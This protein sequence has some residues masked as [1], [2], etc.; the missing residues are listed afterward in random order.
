TISFCDEGDIVLTTNPAYVAY[1]A[2]IKLAGA[3]PYY[4]PLK[5]KNNYLPNLKDIPE[6]VLQKAKLLILNLPGNPVPA[7]P[8]ERFF[9][10]VIEICTTYKDRKRVGKE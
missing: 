9:K 2:G 8:N 3:E 4:M 10:E 1:D 7:M 6:E 5:K